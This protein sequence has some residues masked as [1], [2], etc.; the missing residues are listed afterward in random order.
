MTVLSHGSTPSAIRPKIGAS[1]VTSCFKWRQIPTR[2]IPLMATLVA[3]IAQFAFSHS[4]CLIYSQKGDGD[5]DQ[6]VYLT[7]LAQFALT[8]FT[9]L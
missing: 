4:F 9:L 7:L 6:C 3:S 2:A 8:G 5:T 1:N